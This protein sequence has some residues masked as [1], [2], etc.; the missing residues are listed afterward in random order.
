[1]E[2]GPSPT[3]ASSSEV[4]SA[5]WLSSSPLD[6]ATPSVSSSLES[7]PK[8]SRPENTLSSLSERLESGS[9]RRG[10]CKES[11]GLITATW[12][13]VPLVTHFR[14]RRNHS[15]GLE[16]SSSPASVDRTCPRSRHTSPQS[17]ATNRGNL[18]R[19]HWLCGD[20]FLLTVP[21]KPSF[22]HGHTPHPTVT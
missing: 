22:L 6:P 4:S 18:S 1:M 2:A 13:Q 10:G 7:L 16:P 20:Q 3:C 15:P 8:S 14:L 21:P 11:E 5:L 17:R 19:T 12:K 9:L